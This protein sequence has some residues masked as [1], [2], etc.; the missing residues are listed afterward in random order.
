MLKIVLLFALVANSLACNGVWRTVNAGETC[1]SMCGGTQWGVD[2]IRNTG[3]NVDCNNLRA[4]QAYCL[5]AN[6]GVG[7]TGGNTGTWNNGGWTGG[8]TGTWNNGG[9]TGGNTGT[10]GN[11]GWTGGA[12]NGNLRTLNYG[13]TCW[14]L[15]G[16]QDGVNQATSF[17]VN[18]NALRAGEQVCLPW[19]CNGNGWNGN[20]GTWNN[21]GWT[22]GNT[23]TWNNGQW[24]GNTGT[25]N[26][27][28]WTG[29]TGT[30]S[31]GGWAE[32]A[33]GRGFE[34]QS[35][36]TCE[37]LARQCGVSTQDFLN[38]NSAR[39]VNWDC[40]NLRVGQRLCC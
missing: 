34:V 9:W 21:G 14:S 1:W 4:G 20:T 3:F 40:T 19:G 31:N 8:N 12:C 38:R 15:C 33:S 37:F 2:Q 39:G 25:W 35:G 18:C 30:W 5:P 11:G 32:C 24:D 28:G 36:N 22:G 16:S 27:G 17:G 29:N 26:N 7:W 10:W 6:C 13:D 23:G